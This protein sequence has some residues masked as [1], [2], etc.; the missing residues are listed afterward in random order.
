MSDEINLDEYHDKFVKHFLNGIMRN[1]MLWIISKEK[2]HGYAILKKLDDFF[3]F[4]NCNVDFKTSSSKVYPIL[5]RMEESGLIIGQWD[6][7][8]NNKRVKFYT[9]TDDGLILLNHIK[10]NMEAIFKNPSWIEF[11]KEMTD[12]E[13]NYEKRD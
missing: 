6:V 7:N 3:S 5:N 2:I 13:I 12:L 4:K 8:D 10:A 11:L 9:I 1:L